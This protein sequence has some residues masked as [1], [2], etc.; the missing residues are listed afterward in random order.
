MNATET[1]GGPPGLD[2]KAALKLVILFGVVSLLADMTYE[3]ARSITGPFLGVLG[4]SGAVVGT[5]AGL[6]ELAGY[7]LRLL[8]GVAAERSGRF[9]AFTLAGYAVNLLAVPFLALAGS[10]PA[11][12]VLMIVERTG[13]AVRSPARDT[14]LSYATHR[15]GRGFGFGLHEAMDQTGAVLGPLLVAFMLSRT[16]G[17]RAGF[18][19]LA[20]PAVAALA[21]LAR[22]RFL[23]PHPERFEAGAAQGE[24]A[25]SRALPR[26]FWIYVAAVALTAAGFADFPLVAFHLQ[27]DALFAA[28]AIPLLYALAMGVDAGAAL[29]FG[30]LFD[31]RG[32]GVLAGAA[33]VTALSAPMVFLGGAAFAVAGVVVWGIGM[34]A[35][36]SIMRAA[37]ADLVPPA[38]RGSAYGFMNAAYGGAWFLG[39]AAMGFLY[40]RSPAALAAFA[41]LAELA[42]IPVFLVAARAGRSAPGE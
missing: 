31:R 25:R 39:S 41:V 28:G 30:K 36:E 15:T 8:S 33:A 9:W 19:V 35:Q 22:A 6:G 37:V 18:A 17:Y 11:A 16:G 1:R 21:V 29:L 2:R 20:I 10:W 38:R 4:A 27:R 7:G 26:A 5:V 42:A 12:S 40:D 23:H 24:A 13:K 3:G 32:M 14:M 34:G